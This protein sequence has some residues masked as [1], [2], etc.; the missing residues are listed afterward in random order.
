MKP[1]KLIAALILTLPLAC[2]TRA[3]GGDEKPAETPLPLSC[4]LLAMSPADRVAHLE[5]LK[6]LKRASAAVAMTP[7]GFHFKV[8]L[9][10]MPLKELQTWAQAEQSC[11]SFL[12]IDCQ[13]VEADKQAIVRVVCA[14]D[15]KKEVVSTFGLEPQN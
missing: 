14:A 11:C 9:Q 4:T 7:E 13:V 12:K 5:R 1:S 8:D 6:L 15:E 2:A 3:F 10:T